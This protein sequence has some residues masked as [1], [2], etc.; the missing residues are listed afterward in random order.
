MTFYIDFFLQKNHF[1]SDFSSKI[2]PDDAA[3]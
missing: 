2:L 1:P 3:N